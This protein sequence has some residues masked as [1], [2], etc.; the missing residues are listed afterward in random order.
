MSDYDIQ[1]RLDPSQPVAGAAK[2][3]EAVDK[4]E[5]K[6]KKTAS[7]MDGIAESVKSINFKQAAA[8]ANQA[9]ELLNQKLHITDSAVGSVI[10]SAVK[11]GALGAQIAGPWGA[12]V[13]AVGGAL[14]DLDQKLG[15]TIG[16]AIDMAKAGERQMEAFR[17][18][19]FLAT[20][21]LYKMTTGFE[22]LHKVLDTL[23]QARAIAS[24]APGL[25]AL[26]QYN[27][28]MERQKKLLEDIRSPRRNYHAEVDSLNA[29]L[30]AGKIDQTEFDRGLAAI[31]EKFSTGKEKAKEA[32]AAVHELNAEFK[33][34][35]DTIGRGE[36]NPKEP[37]AGYEAD[38]ALKRAQAAYN[39]HQPGD[40][41]RM[42]GK[43]GLNVLD[44]SSE[45]VDKAAEAWKQIGVNTRAWNLELEKSR[46]DMAKLQAFAQ[47]L[48]DELANLFA[49]GEFGWKRMIDAMIRDAARL[50]EA[51][52][53]SGSL[54]GSGDGLVAGG[55]PGIMSIA[56]ASAPYY[57]GAHAT[58]G[59]YTAPATGG[60]PDSIPVLFRMNPRETA[61]F[62]NPG[63][64]RAPAAVAQP[65]AAAPVNVYLVDQRDPRALARTADFK[66]VIR[67]VILDNPS[68]IR[69]LI[70]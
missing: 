64:A 18:G 47:P 49:T 36:R 10:G 62:T 13:G 30:K 2:V 20:D 61:T 69:G 66:T 14:V 46:E 50:A 48:Q 8:G 65:A 19:I 43:K 60:G 51:K 38:E 59:S 68:L 32:T 5:A 3:T 23:G 70:R 16:G 31:N 39:E 63:Q 45:G 7:A 24:T 9:F 12:A 58:G 35:F 53:F 26:Q 44:G 57:G 67:E 11:F 6:A 27:E 17:R 1:I 54:F 34:L 33:A 21:Q 29:M 25:I 4:I 41:D 37:Y 52:L 55:G 56:Q 40:F 28:E 22:A 15:N 42:I